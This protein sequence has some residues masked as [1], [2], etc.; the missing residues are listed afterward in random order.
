MSHRGVISEIITLFVIIFHFFA[1]LIILSAVS[2]GLSD[3]FKSLVPQ[4]IMILL[5]SL[6]IIGWIYDSMSFVVA[7]PKYLTTTFSVSFDILSS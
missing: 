6:L 5:G 1:R 2:S 7:P 3:D 4:Y